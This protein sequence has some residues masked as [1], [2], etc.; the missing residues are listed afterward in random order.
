MRCYILV[1]FGL[2]STSLHYQILTKSELDPKSHI[3]W[4]ITFMVYLTYSP[5]ILID[6]IAW[7]KTA[8]SPLLTHWRYCSLALRHRHVIN[9]AWLWIEISNL[10]RCDL[11][12]NQRHKIWQHCYPH[13]WTSRSHYPSWNPNDNQTPHLPKEHNRQRRW[14]IMWPKLVPNYLGVLPYIH[15]LGLSNLQSCS[16]IW[17]EI[18]LIAKELYSYDRNV[19]NITTSLFLVL[20]R[21]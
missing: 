21:E 18:P 19:W 14:S 1:N 10:V 16:V 2:G 9:Q 7:Y 13:M 6:P 15:A 8:I 3:Y 5:N 17:L 11:F 4:C 12:E 20:H